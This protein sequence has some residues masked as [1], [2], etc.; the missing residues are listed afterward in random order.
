MVVAGLNLGTMAITV[1]WF[2][3]MVMLG[4]VCL[5]AVPLWIYNIERIW[6]CPDNCFG[7]GCDD[8]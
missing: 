1:D 8:G 4:S 7:Q 5:Y 3:V 6:I 2:N